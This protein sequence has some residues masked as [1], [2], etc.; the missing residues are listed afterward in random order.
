LLSTRLRTTGTSFCYNVGRYITAFGVSILGPLAQLLHGHTSLPGFRLA[1][2]LL[3]CCYLAGVCAL[4]WAPETVNQPL[5]E[6]EKGL[7]H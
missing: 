5:P 6:D 4:I 7:S 3:S 1:A 2:M